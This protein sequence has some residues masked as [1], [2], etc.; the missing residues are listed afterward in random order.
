LKQKI[1]V[2]TTFVDHCSK[3]VQTN[4]D[5]AR[6]FNSVGSL[7][8]GIHMLTRLYAYHTWGGYIT[9]AIDYNY[10]LP[11]RLRLRINKITMQ[12]ITITLKVIMI[13]IEITFVLKHLQNGKKTHLHGLM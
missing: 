3:G 7:C 10:L 6:I 12:S 2:E 1:L 4:K 11:A 8:L 13:T 9:N 5:A